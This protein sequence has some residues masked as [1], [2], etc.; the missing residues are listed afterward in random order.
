MFQV[1]SVV[2][3]C[4]MRYLSGIANLIGSLLPETVPKPWRNDATKYS[5][6]IE[7]GNCKFC[8]CHDYFMLSEF[9]W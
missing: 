2:E 5:W 7:V 6:A 1:M 8:C 3:V 4:A 9:C